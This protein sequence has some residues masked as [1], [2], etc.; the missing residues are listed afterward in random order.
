MFFREDTVAITT[1]DS[2]FAITPGNGYFQMFA[3]GEATGSRPSI[4]VCKL[5]WTGLA[6]AFCVSLRRRT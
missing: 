4:C 3:S 2:D 1:A 6:A 5:G